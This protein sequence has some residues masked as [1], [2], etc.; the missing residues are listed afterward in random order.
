MIPFFL[1]ISRFH[2]YYII[3]SGLILFHLKEFVYGLFPI[4]FTGM[5]NFVRENLIII[6]V[7]NIGILFWGIYKSNRIKE[8]ELS[9]WVYLIVALINL[10][11]SFIFFWIVAMNCAYSFNKQTYIVK[12]STLLSVILIIIALGWSYMQATPTE[13]IND[14]IEVYEKIDL[15]GFD[16]K[17]NWDYGYFYTYLTKKDTNYFGGYNRRI[18]NFENTITITNT[19]DEIMNQYNCE[20]LE[21]EKDI[22]LV[23]CI[24]K[25]E[26]IAN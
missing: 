16:K 25:K 11:L 4:L 15:N 2:I 8:L 17:V 9:L 26:T 1:I 12:Y 22:A 18:T 19:S 5:T 7:V 24:N 20:I 3:G 21:K 23:K 13:P 10:K 6:G 14:M